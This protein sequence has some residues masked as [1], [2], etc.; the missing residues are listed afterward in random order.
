MCTSGLTICLNFTLLT[1]DTVN[2]RSHPCSIASKTIASWAIPGRMGSPGKCPENH[3]ESKPVSTL[4]DISFDADRLSSLIECQL[5]E[6]LLNKL[7]DM[8][9]KNQVSLSSM[10]V[11]KLPNPT[12][13]APFL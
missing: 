5:I 12:T 2:F 6:S 11:T 13:S 1:P 10:A 7:S 3:G 4:A 8:Y 9:K